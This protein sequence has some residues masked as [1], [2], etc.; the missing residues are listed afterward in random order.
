MNEKGTAFLLP[1]NYS[2]LKFSVESNKASGRP[3]TSAGATSR[4][5]Q[6]I[7]REVESI[8]LDGD[9]AF[10][11]SQHAWYYTKGDNLKRSA[12]PV[13]KYLS[14]TYRRGE[15]KNLVEG[16]SIKLF[17]YKN[18]QVVVDTRVVLVHDAHDLVVLQ[19]ESAELCD[20][21][22]FLEEV[23]PKKGM[24]SVLMSYSVIRGDASHLSFS[25]GTISSDISSRMRFLG[26]SS[27]YEGNTGG[28]CWSE[29][30][31]LIGMQVEADTT[32]SN[33]RQAFPSH[34]FVH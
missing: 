11:I 4:K 20:R 7:D 34:Q 9:L 10:R 19:S 33:G 15:N 22:L 26:S 17:S 31:K 18:Q 13:A 25:T 3:S 8:L 24:K 21:N 14:I 23:E 12:I 29:D 32:D 27:S 28:S 2:H 6:M 30:G 16:D 5:R 1:D